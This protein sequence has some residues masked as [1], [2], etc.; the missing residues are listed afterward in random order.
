MSS[1]SFP[2]CGVFKHL[3]CYAAVFWWV[4]ACFVRVSCRYSHEQE[5]VWH[6]K[7]TS[8]WEAWD[9]FLLACQRNA[10]STVPANCKE[11]KKG[12]VL[13]YMVL[14][15][16]CPYHRVSKLSNTESWHR[17]SGQ[18]HDF[19]HLFLHQKHPDLIWHS[20]SLFGNSAS[21]VKR[22]TCK[23]ICKHGYKQSKMHTGHLWH[24]NITKNLKTHSEI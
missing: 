14:T 11:E 18:I 8:L 9:T 17:P 21:F 19:F 7:L 10:Y 22:K 13:D 1:A 4:G 6:R 5:D 12:L 23:Y 24:L 2:P 15:K 3:S 20:V 16:M